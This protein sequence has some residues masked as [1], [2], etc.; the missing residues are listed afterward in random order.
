MRRSETAATSPQQKALRFHE[1]LENSAGRLDLPPPNPDGHDPADRHR[2]R[3][4]GR[5]LRNRDFH[6]VVK[7]V[8]SRIAARAKIE[9]PNVIDLARRGERTGKCLVDCSD[10]KEIN[11]ERVGGRAGQ[12]EDG[13][14]SVVG[15]PLRGELLSGTGHG[16]TGIT[17]GEEK[18]EKVGGAGTQSEPDRVTVGHEAV[19]KIELERPTCLQRLTERPDCFGGAVSRAIAAEGP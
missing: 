2:P 16:V 13:P 17:T 18:F 11:S 6:A 5:W 14:H 4:P 3:Q 15:E 7:R 8:A 1:G 12:L 9:K 19:V 10:S